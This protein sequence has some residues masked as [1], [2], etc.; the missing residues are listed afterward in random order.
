MPVIKNLTKTETPAPT[1]AVARY[2]STAPAMLPDVKPNNSGSYI[3]CYDKDDDKSAD[4]LDA[5]GIPL[6]ELYL[7]LEGAATRVNPLQFHLLD[8]R[9]FFT[10]MNPA[11]E[12]AK[13][14]AAE[15]EGLD[16]HFVTLL[17]VRVG[18]KLVPSCS[19]FRK[20]K[21]G[22]AKTAVAAL[23]AAHDPSWGDK[24]ELHKV[25]MRV[26]EPW[27]RFIVTAT[28]RKQV[29]KGSGM[30]YYAG[31]ATVKPVGLDDIARYSAAFQDA[32]F[33][34]AFEAA[35]EA[36]KE[37]VAFLTGKVK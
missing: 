3:A 15:R 32:E 5:A 1:T 27:G 37:R 21:S 16:E 7:R 8:A 23:K 34:E 17:L 14:A 30:P 22:I 28:T 19:T 18:D 10:W 25:T 29:G 33:L 13:V 26:P 35:C 4:E 2:Q 9:M 12:L 6:G 36:F 31:R 11:G 20:T 24:S